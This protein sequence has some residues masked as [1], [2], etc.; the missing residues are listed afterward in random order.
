MG[1]SEFCSLILFFFPPHKR[2]TIS[3]FQQIQLHLSRWSFLLY[4][5]PP[6]CFTYVSVS[7][8]Y[9]SQETVSRETSALLNPGLF[10]VKQ[11]NAMIL[12]TGCSEAAKL[13][14]PGWATTT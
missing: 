1:A 4:K 12:A 9:V 8:P 11:F 13:L 7:Q 2:R 10:L 5:K 3:W 6:R 14:F